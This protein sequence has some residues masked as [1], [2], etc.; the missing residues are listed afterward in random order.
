VAE[1]ERNTRR[2]T[3]GEVFGLALAL[4]TTVAQLLA[5]AE[6]FAPPDASLRIALPSGAAVSA[7]DLAALLYRA[8]PHAITWDGDE[9]VFK[10]NGLASS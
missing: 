9:P 2:V 6:P 10:P 4:D 1:V 5:P 7:D 8:N 3:A